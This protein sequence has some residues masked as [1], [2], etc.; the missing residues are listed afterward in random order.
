GLE[1]VEQR[2]QVLADLVAD[3]VQCGLI[4]QQL[5]IMNQP[6]PGGMSAARQVLTSDADG[7]TL[8]LLTNGTAV[9]AAL[10]TNL[11]FDPVNDFVPV[12]TLGLFD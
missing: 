3:A 8:A 7:Y 10:Y 11:Q 5:T 6:G 4:G 1:Q 12:S 9:S 2:G